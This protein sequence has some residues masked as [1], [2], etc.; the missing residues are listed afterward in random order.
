MHMKSLSIL[1]QAEC[2]TTVILLTP[3][4]KSFLSSE[5]ACSADHSRGRRDAFLEKPRPLEVC[6]ELKDYEPH[7]LLNV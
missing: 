6:D 3:L 4:N 5:G 7:R 1:G 2:S